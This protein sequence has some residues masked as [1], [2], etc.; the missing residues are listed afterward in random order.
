MHVALHFD[1]DYKSLGIFYGDSIHKAFFRT[2]LSY[3]GTEV[4]TEIYTGDL[5]F[6]S[7]SLATGV[8][9][10]SRYKASNEQ[11][12]HNNFEVWLESIISGYASF[13]L[14]DISSCYK[15]NIYVISLRTVDLLLAEYL[16]SQLKSLPYYLGALEVDETCQIHRK[17]YL[18]SLLPL[19]RIINNSAKVF[20]NKF[21]GEERDE[22]L[23]NMLGDV[24]FLDVGYEILV[25]M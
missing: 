7:L 4:S 16:A 6:Y 14:D 10:A 24:G 5:N 20:W 2:M 21:N 23:L 13:Q 11:K 18:M 22:Y 12:Y 17:I 8:S 3:R 19:C 25:N 1:A 15:K 9:A